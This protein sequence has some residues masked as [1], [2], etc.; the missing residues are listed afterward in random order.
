M[1][2]LPYRPISCAFYDLILS[3][4]QAKKV[5]RIVYYT[6]EQKQI[7]IDAIIEDVYSKE[8]EEFLRVRNDHLIR[9][10]YILSIASF[11]KSS[12]DKSCNIPN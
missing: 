6:P 2:N 10:D 11:H 9:L 5:V 1:N 4:S 3:F 8:G 12:Y 7:S